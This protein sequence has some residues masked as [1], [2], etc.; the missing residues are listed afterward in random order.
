MAEVKA[1]PKGYHT[2]T[3][4]IVVSE[5]AKAIDFYKKA[6]GAEELVRMPGPGGGIMHAELRIGDSVVMLGEEMP[7]MGAKSPKAYGGSPVGFYVY[8]ENVDAAWE[9]AVKAGA[10]PVMPLANMFWGDRTGRLEDP[11][12][13]NWSLAQHVEDLTPEEIKQGQ[14]A[15][16][17]QLQTT[18]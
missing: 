18:P 1:I 6:F 3:P 16:F 4:N 11:F 12:G 17:A 15:F 14:E 9:R 10:K 5:G 7:D 2:I 13:H 8:V